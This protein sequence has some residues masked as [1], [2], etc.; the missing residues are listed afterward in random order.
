MSDQTE[1]IRKEIS[2]IEEEIKKLKEIQVLKDNFDSISDPNKIKIAEDAFATV[3]SMVARI[4]ELKAE[5][6]KENVAD[7]Q[8]EQLEK[9]NAVSFDL[10]TSVTPELLKILVDAGAKPDFIN[11]VKTDVV[12][13]KLP[14]YKT[15]LQALIAK[16]APYKT[17]PMS[18]KTKQWKRAVDDF[19]NWKVLGDSSI[20]YKKILSQIIKDSAKVNTYYTKQHTT[21]YD[22]GVM[23]KNPG[24]DRDPGN[25]AL[26]IQEAD[27]SYG[28]YYDLPVIAAIP[29]GLGGLGAWVGMGKPQINAVDAYDLAHPITTQPITANDIEKY[30]TVSGQIIKAEQDAKKTP[31]VTKTATDM[32]AA[33]TTIPDIRNNKHQ[34]IATA[35]E[36]LVKDFMDN[37]LEKE[38]RAGMTGGGDPEDSIIRF[39]RLSAASVIATFIIARHEKKLAKLQKKLDD[40]LSQEQSVPRTKSKVKK[41][42][43]L[44]FLRPLWHL[45]KYQIADVNS[46]DSKLFD[47]CQNM[48]L[49][50]EATFAV[51]LATDRQDIMDLIQQHSQRNMH[52]VNS[53]LQL[54]KISASQKFRKNWGVIDNLKMHGLLQQNNYRF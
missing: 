53:L 27:D 36:A 14:K 47:V 17:K 44:H 35:L 15:Q 8:R 28:F 49:S 42:K 50:V 18:G 13:S 30:G 34:T 48:G 52:L 19:T 25:S 20:E 16:I 33:P 41:R 38:I 40:L 1:E 31:S 3:M 6:E 21:T 23:K 45:I 7:F 12:L 37:D 10:D 5:I 24:S 51:F 39:L 9:L 22:T 32:I 54:K 2:K 43:D 26:R 29:G 46:Y 4:P 11:N